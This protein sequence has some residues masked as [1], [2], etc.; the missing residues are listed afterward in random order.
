MWK[1]SYDLSIE[2]KNVGHYDVGLSFAGEQREFVRQ[3]ADIIKSVGL[4]V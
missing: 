1:S 3:V 4:Q 2:M